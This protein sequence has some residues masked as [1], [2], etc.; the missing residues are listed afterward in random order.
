MRAL[1]HGVH[2]PQHGG[3]HD[4]RQRRGVDRPDREHHAARAPPDRASVRRRVARTVNP[5]IHPSPAHG[6]SI[7]E[8]RDTYG[9]H[10]RAGLVDDGGDECC[11][12]CRAR[13]G[14]HTTAR[15]ARRP[16]A[17]CRSTAGGR[18][19]RGR[20][21]CSNSQYHGPGRPQVGDV[22]VRHPSGEL[23]RV[24]ARGGVAEEAARIEVQ[25]ELAVG[26]HPAGRGGQRGQVREHR[27]CGRR[28]DDRPAPPRRATARSLPR[29]S[30][31]SLTGSRRTRR[32]GR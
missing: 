10:V 18:S 6:S 12:S 8:V 9:Q 11:R 14:E 5:T 2:D 3:G 27:Q 32:T 26:R 15:P 1:P 22:L 29:R 19:S 13:A 20:A 4:H 16:A 21:A 31:R 28:R 30:P 17:A 23:A 25:V 7:T 24:E